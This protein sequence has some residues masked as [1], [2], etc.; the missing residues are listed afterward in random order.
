[1]GRPGTSATTVSAG[2]CL[3]TSRIP[4]KGNVSVLATPNEAQEPAAAEEAQELGPARPKRT[5]R[6]PGWLAS[7]VWVKPGL[8]TEEQRGRAI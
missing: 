6:A 1:M 5:R 2:S 4:R 7:H 3:G 8:V